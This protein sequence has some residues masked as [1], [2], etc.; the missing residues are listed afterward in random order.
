MSLIID[1]FDVPNV[2]HVCQKINSNISSFFKCKLCN[3]P[4]TARRNYG[5]IMNRKKLEPNKMTS[6]T[7]VNLKL[8]MNR[9][10][11]LKKITQ[12]LQLQF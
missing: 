6:L 7:R 9:R 2:E 12:T 4:E 3:Q 1:H 5:Q 10:A 8:P 11:C